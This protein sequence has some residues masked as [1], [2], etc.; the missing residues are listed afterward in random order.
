MD[1][2]L[3][4]TED[5]FRAEV[6]QFIAD[7]I[8]ASKA[9]HLYRTGTL[10]DP[11]FLQALAAKNWL[12]GAIGSE[13]ASNDLTAWEL[14]IIDEEFMGAEAPVYAFGT[15]QGVARAI[16]EFGVEE[17]K[18][19]VCAKA[20]RGELTIAF[21]FS[22]PESG[23][24][25]ANA[26]TRAVRD[27]DD[28]IIN[29]SKMFTTNARVTDYVYVLTR[30]NTEVAKHKGLTMFLVPTSLPGFEAQAVWTVSGERTNITYYSDMRIADKYRIGEVDGGWRV[31]LHTLQ[32]E[33]T[34]GFGP[35]LQK[36]LE[37]AETWA[38]E[39]VGPEGRP[40]TDELDVQ[41]RLGRAYADLEVGLADP[42][43]RFVDGTERND[44][45]RGGSDGQALY[46]RSAGA[47]LAG[48]LRDDGSGRD[49]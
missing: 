24:D 3:G 36:L 15:T 1:F 14:R 9:E 35:H 16:A 21:G 25:V 47:C 40:R 11:E 31:L 27:G 18:D 33:H 22:E 17:L 7:N 19:E 26:Q 49:A 41:A 12:G 39:T 13:R 2:K 42:A 5:E 23:S 6:K 28:W 45:D 32:E 30:S 44:P 20:F 46:L 8:P 43:A 34:V 10:H 29:G 4:P 38:H 37:A 48:P